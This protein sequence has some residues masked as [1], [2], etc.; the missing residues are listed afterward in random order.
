MRGLVVLAA[1]TIG[2]TVLGQT[3][4]DSLAS[5]YAKTITGKDLRSRLEIIASDEFEGRETGKE[6]QKKAAAYIKD[7]FIE[8]G[9]G[10]TEELGGYYQSYKL[11][12]TYP[13]TVNL[14]VGADT[15][16]FL[17]DMYYFPGFGDMLLK[18][19]QVKYHGFG[20]SDS[21]YDDYGAESIEG[22]VVMISSGEPKCKDGTSMITETAKPSDW[23][24]DWSKKIVLAQSKGARALIIIDQN[25]ASS[26]VQF[27]KF[28]QRPLIQLDASGDTERESNMPIIFIT[29]KMADRILRAGG[30]KKGHKKLEQGI[31]K[32]GVP[33]RLEMGIPIT[34]EVNKNR[35]ELIAEN[36]LGFMKGTEKP[37]E[38]VVVTAHYDHLGRKGDDIYNGAD[39]DG[40]GTTTLLEIAQAFAQAQKEG[41]GPKRSILFMTVSGEEKGLLGSEFYTDNPV[42]PL[43]NTIANLNIDMI[44]RIDKHHAPDSNYVYII[45]SDKLSTELHQL[46]ENVNSTYTGIELDYK[47]N[48]ERD[49]NRFY[50]RSDHYNFAKNRIPVI[51]YFTGVHEDYHQPTD[52]VDKIMFGKMENIARL[53]FHTAWELAN[54]EDRPKVDKAE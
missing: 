16:R 47:Y 8:F 51:F 48:D 52:T 30:Y 9:I 20:I 21:K 26:V 39:D 19:E 23:T 38:V 14:L 28:I 53:I 18:V 5:R 43:A 31:G 46:S 3:N 36:V 11:K 40:S 24:S 6:G 42:F 27:G 15:V 12:L 44:G 49:P 34:I 41:N 35:E 45:G 50:Y 10:P 1:C 54:R 37:E 25:F 22:N 4:V 32:S 29:T 2:S 17:K 33:Q 13:D 7:R